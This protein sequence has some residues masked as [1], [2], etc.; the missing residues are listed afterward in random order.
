MAQDLALD[1]PLVHTDSDSIEDTQ[2]PGNFQVTVLPDHMEVDEDFLDGKLASLLGSQG[3]DPSSLIE[4]EQLNPTD[5]IAR[6][7]V[8]VVDFRIPQPSW[9]HQPWSAREHLS[10][11]QDS[12]TVIFRLPIAPQDG[13]LDGSLQW[14]PICGNDAVPAMDELDVDAGSRELLADKHLLPS[15]HSGSYVSFSSALAILDLTED[16]DIEEPNGDESGTQQSVPGHVEVAQENIS[17]ERE[18]LQPPLT[19]SKTSRAAGS[20]SHSTRIDRGNALLPLSEDS[21]ATTTLLSGFMELRAVKRPRFGRSCDVTPRRTMTRPSTSPPSSATNQ[22]L[23]PQELAQTLEPAPTPQY[24]MPEE[25]G[26]CIVSLTLERPILRHLEKSW[27]SHLILDR[28]YSQHDLHP[29]SLGT[30]IP[31]QQASP[32]CFEADISMSPGTGVIVTT[33][34]KAKQKA[35]PGSTAQTPLRERVQR[36]SQKYQ[37][38]AILV[39]EANPA[40]E[41]SSNYSSSDMAAYAG[42]VRFAASLDA[43]VTTYLVPG[44]DKTLCEWIIALL[45]RQSPQSAAL[46][47]LVSPAETSWDLFLRRAGLNVFAAQVLSRTLLEEFGKAGLAQFLAMPTQ[48]KVLKYSQ[49]AG[50]EQVLAR[51][52]EVLDRGW[53]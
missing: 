3:F 6:V 12:S 21:S 7:P 47:G 19:G 31:R 11:L 46:R 50:G 10:R 18:K 27:P 51:C 14:I 23:A 48:A 28:D 37:K 43:E 30:E 9:V 4:Q 40:G 13:R 36:T 15:S 38:L 20:C 33:L 16:R 25:K 34:V 5:S 42:F 8:P 17:Q 29:R 32:F 39:S 24:D 41:F 44:A 35:L 53:A 26:P 52:C 2:L 1:V 45:C 49:L 22:L